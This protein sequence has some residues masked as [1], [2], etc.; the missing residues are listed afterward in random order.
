ML[1]KGEE[2]NEFELNIKGYEFSENASDWHDA[3]WLNIEI[4]ARGPRGSWNALAPVLLTEEAEYLANWL[5][6]K[7]WSP[8]LDG[9]EFL[10]PTLSFAV[11]EES[12]E[13]LV[14]RVLFWLEF[15]PPWAEGS[16][17]RERIELSLKRKDLASASN[18][19][20]AQLS[21]YPR[22][23]P[24]QPEPNARSTSSGD[25]AFSA[26]AAKLLKPDREV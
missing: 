20:R 23:N 17:T 3:N 12:E 13:N 15:L 5:E 26:H 9:I 18:S 19:L 11:V 10:E 7:T 4:R 24:D 14:L 8:A 25:I 21:M 1:L 16:G 6:K 2:G 22:R